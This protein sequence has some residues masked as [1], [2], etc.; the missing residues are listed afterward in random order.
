MRERAEKEIKAQIEE[1]RKRN[2]TVTETDIYIDKRLFFNTLQIELG[3]RP[4]RLEEYFQLWKQQG[5]F[6]NPRIYEGKF[7][8][9]LYQDKLEAKTLNPKKKPKTK[10]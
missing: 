9:T 2:G 7:T 5:V 1:A 8:L 6:W 3:V 10:P 4:Q